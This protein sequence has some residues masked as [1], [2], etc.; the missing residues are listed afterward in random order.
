MIRHQGYNLIDK[1]GYT[2]HNT[3][4]EH[5]QASGRQKHKG[6]SRCNPSYNQLPEARINQTG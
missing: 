4:N 5:N 2:F 1:P 6:N 3:V